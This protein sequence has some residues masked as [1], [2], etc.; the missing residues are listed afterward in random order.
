MKVVEVN[1]WATTV[2]VDPGGT[3]GWGVMSVSPSLL[4]GT[5]PI[6]RSISHWACGNYKGNEDQMAS[7][8]LQLF[9]VW[10]DAAIGIER[11]VIRKFLQHHEFLSPVRIRAKIE[12][13]LW[14]QEKWESEDDGRVMGRGRY[15]FQQDPSLAKSVLTDERQR[16]YALWEP[17]PDHQRDAIKHCYTFLRRAQEKPR[18]RATAWPH[19]FTTDGA[20]LKKRP[21]TSK[22]S[23]RGR[24]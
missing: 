11:F 13:G 21:P 4:T 2:W 14:L 7:E 9:S 5:K 15:L 23:T 6:H 12:Y 17:G 16:E 24:K 10:D 3:T 20:L 19:L 18:L 1:G 8:M 22:A